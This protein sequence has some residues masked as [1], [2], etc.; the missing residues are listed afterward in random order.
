MINK[1]TLEHVENVITRKTRTT[2]T[3]E[4]IFELNRKF[5]FKSIYID[6]G[7]GSLGVGVF[8]HLLNNEDTKR[9]V[10]AINN[11]ALSMDRENKKKQILMKE[12][13]YDNMRWLMEKGHL[14][15]LDD[16]EVKLSLAS[17]QYEFTGGDDA[18]EK[19]VI[20]RMRIFGNYTH[21]VEGLIRACW[22]VK[23]K[24]LNIWISSFRI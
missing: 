12:D 24:N 18:V 17:V 3:E 14:K 1:E 6:A 21:I 15:L 16:P 23:D 2:E 9:K 22:I 19:G 8:D 4:R 5:D 13:L 7:S 11:R 20:T 10:V